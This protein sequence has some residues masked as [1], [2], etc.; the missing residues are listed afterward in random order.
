MR[1]LLNTLYISSP[2]VYLGR[3]GENIVIKKEYE[4]FKRLPIHILEGIVC[5]NHIGVSPGLMDLCNENNIP[6]S[7]H[8][9]NGK[10][11]GVLYGSE[12]GNVLLRRD[13]Y[14]LADSKCKS[15]DISKMFIHGKIVNSGTV[16][17][18]AIRDH[19]D[20]INISFLQNALKQ[21]E[22]NLEKLQTVDNQD[23]LRGIEGDSAKI[24][25]SCFDE[26]IFNK[27]FKFT[28][29]SKRPPENEFNAMLSFFYSILTY[30][31]AN[32]LNSVGLDP[33][34][35]FFHVDRPG[36]RSLALDILEEFRAYMVDRFVI[37]S[38]N[39]R[40]IKIKDFEF[41]ENG[42]V[43]LKDSGRDKLIDLWQ[44]KKQVEVIH[45]FL[46]ERV[47]L[48]LLPYIQAKLLAKYIRGEIELY[49]PFLSR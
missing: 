43:L 31:C 26:I 45:P 6:I 32:A 23:I 46:N 14:R 1:K 39:L 4:V 42:S 44:K 40:T 19:S 25:F 20:K 10:F 13:Q 16:L 7:F 38:I 37:S 41:K 3:E 2:D 18:R 29:R 21:L 24:Y 47:K 48:G 30:E 33:Y 49:P 27:D 9:S 15:L 34:V 22:I 35:G 36:R 28:Q 8:K 5:F 17:K 12:N 11:C